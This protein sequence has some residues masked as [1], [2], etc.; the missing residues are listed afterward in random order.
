MSENQKV[1]AEEIIRTHVLWSMG[2]G[3]VPVPVVD[4]IAV[5]YVQVDMLKQLSGLYGIN[6]EENSGK[7]Y[8]SALVGSS[9]ARL[10][11]SFIKGI[12][13]LGSWIGGV[14]MAVLSGASTYALGQVFTNHFENGGD[15]FNFDLDW[16]KKF[17]EQNF[18]QGKTY[19]SDLNEKEKKKEDNWSREEIL[20]RLE[21]LV[22]LKKQGIL[23]EEEFNKKREEWL[24]KLNI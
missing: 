12:P 8:I 13:G 18:E 15:F 4:F 9:L 19:A 24:K 11:S 2:A 6:F 7:N 10:G 20:K 16:A 21:N 23:T 1:K 14:S 3:A 17:Y 22:T 5:T